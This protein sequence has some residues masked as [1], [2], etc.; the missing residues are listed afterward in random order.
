VHLLNE[1]CATVRPTVTALH[2]IL[3]GFNLLYFI[4]FIIFFFFLNCFNYSDFFF[5]INF[6]YVK[7]FEL[8]LCYINKLALP[9][10]NVKKFDLKE[11]DLTKTLFMYEVG[12]KN[13]LFYSKCLV[14]P[15]I[16]N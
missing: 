13:T 10:L 12:K 1:H 4:F 15:C 5:W 2:F 11:L 16:I 3:N 7:H 6:F 8:P 9:C 14:I